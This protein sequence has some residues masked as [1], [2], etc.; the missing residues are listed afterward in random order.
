M[1]LCPTRELAVQVAEE[2]SKLALFKKGI[3]ELPVYGGA[4]Y[5]RQLRG[6]RDGAQII[7]GTPGRIMDHLQRGTLSLAEVGTVVL[8]EADRMLDM[9]FRDD[10]EV[11][12][13]QA[14]TERQTVL[15]SATMPPALRDII[16]RFTREAVNVRIEK[17][18]AHRARH[19]AGVLRGRTAL[20][21]GSALPD[22]RPGRRA[23]GDRVL[24]DQ[25]HGR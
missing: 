17:P 2:V 11:I 3:R 12:L 14:P 25:G 21:A 23:A 19:R 1:I 10:I 20:E 7:I 9:G 16:K 15:F 22:S 24:R 8:D 5:E 18:G 6:L 13:K 4:S